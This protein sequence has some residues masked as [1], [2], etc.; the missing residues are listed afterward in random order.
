MVYAPSQRD[1]ARIDARYYG[2]RDGLAS[3]YRYDL[4]LSPS[5]GLEEREQHPATRVEWV[6]PG[7]VW[8]ESHAQNIH[9]S[10]PWPMVSGV[11]TYAK[12]ET[13]RLDWFRRRSAPASATPSGSRT[14]AGR[15]T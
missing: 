4:T 7:Q 1:L 8:V 13:T 2:V 5:L 3:G 14:P 9:G 10:L 6:T 11:N 15:T 12:G